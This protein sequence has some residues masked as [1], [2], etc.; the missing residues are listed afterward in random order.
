MNIDKL[1]RSAGTIATWDFQTAIDKKKSIHTKLAEL[2]NV[3]RAK[4]AKAQVFEVGATKSIVENLRPFM[5][6]ATGEFSDAVGMI[7]GCWAIY[8]CKSSR[9]NACAIIKGGSKIAF[10]SICNLEP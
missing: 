1:A 3:L 7:D 6:E 5:E 2:T 8:E 9:D 10:M 4:G